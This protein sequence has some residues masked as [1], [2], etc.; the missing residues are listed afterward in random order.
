MP[1]EK[2]A[3]IIK[4]FGASRKISKQ[5]VSLQND[6]GT[7][8][9]LYIAIQDQLAQAYSEVRNEEAIKKFGKPYQELK[10]SRSAVDNEKAKVIRLLIPQRISEAEPKEIGS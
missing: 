6:R 3:T 10:D 1:P 4:H 2:N 8:Y 7:S 5:I 9:E